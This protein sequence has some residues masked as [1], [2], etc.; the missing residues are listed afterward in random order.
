MDCGRLGH[1]GAAQFEM[2][3]ALGAQLQDA[4]GEG[5]E[6]VGI[7]HAARVGAEGLQV[8]LDVGGVEVGPGL[9]EGGAEARRHGH[10]A[11]ARP[12]VAQRDHALF[13]EAVD[14]GVDGRQ[15]GLVDRP[16]LKVILQVAAH[17]LQLLHHLDPVAA[18]VLGPA[19]AGDHQQLRR[20]DGARAQDHLARGADRLD[21]ALVHHLEPGAAPALEGQPPRG[22]AGQHGQVGPR[23]GRVQ[24]GHRRGTAP[25]VA[26]GLLEMR[27]AVLPGAVV[28]GIVGITRVDPRADVEVDH[29]A[30][31]QA[32]RD[33]QRPLAPAQRVV[34]AAALVALGPLEQ[35]QHLVPRPAAAAHLRPAVVILRLAAHVEQPVD[36]GRAAQHLA[37]RPAQG[38]T[39][40][41]GVGLGHQAPVGA[42]VAHGLEVAD[43]H[44][45]PGIAVPP[46]R[47]EHRHAVAAVGAE[48]VGQH[49]ARRARAH[50]DVIEFHQIPSLW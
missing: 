34:A 47:F 12:K 49:A 6:R 13:P 31:H 19:D 33:G 3:R 40:E 42:G 46:A 48:T 11:L 39:V 2:P 9:E 32:V 25:P 10:R 26:H 20:G 43:R 35:R 23:L 41:A 8:E 1:V 7:G 30:F 18:Q 15:R 44:V 14:L 50:D 24:V 28:V 27:H 16:R 37:A 21:R 38:A 17:A 22:A 29:L 45:D 36:R 4:G 5:V